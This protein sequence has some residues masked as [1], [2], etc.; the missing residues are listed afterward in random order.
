L[1][2]IFRLAN[3]SPLRAANVE[4]EFSLATQS[5]PP[6]RSLPDEN[7]SQQQRWRDPVNRTSR[8]LVPM[9]IALFL[10]QCAWFIRTQSFTN[11]EP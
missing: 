2:N 7:T 8:I 6:T 9:L 3:Q 1:T 10:A 5:E 4:S 11:D